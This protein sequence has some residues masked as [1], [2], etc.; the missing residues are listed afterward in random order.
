MAPEITYEVWVLPRGYG[1]IYAVEEGAGS[2]KRERLRIEVGN[3]SV[4][5]YFNT[6]RVQLNVT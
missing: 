5:A 2:T 3:K 1:S 6:V 4:I